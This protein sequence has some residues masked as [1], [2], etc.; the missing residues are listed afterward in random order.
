MYVSCQEQAQLSSNEHQQQPE[1]NY[2]IPDTPVHASGR[3]Q[4]TFNILVWYAHIDGN[5]E[6]D[7]LDVMQAALDNHLMT[8]A[9][10]SAASFRA[11]RS[12]VRNAL[13]DLASLDL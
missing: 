8:Y 13:A 4:T 9:G 12:V 10:N 11:S 3:Q 2:T 5:S 1:S 6:E 7:A